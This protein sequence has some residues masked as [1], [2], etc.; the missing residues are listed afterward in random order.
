VDAEP[1]MP[2]LTDVAPTLHISTIKSWDNIAEWY[3]DIS[4][5]RIED[6][7]ELKEVYDSIFTNAKDLTPLKKAQKIYNYILGNIRYSHTSFRQGAYVPQKPSVTLNTRL[8]DC[9]DLS[10]LFVSLATM[11]GLKSHLVL[12]DTRDNGL[13]EM[14]LPSVEFNHCIVL[15]EAE[16][17]DYYLELT[18][19]E[20]PFG[21][22][23]YNL[24]GAMSL[25]I[26]TH[27]VEPMVGLLKP[28]TASHRSTDKVKRSG[29]IEFDGSDLKMKVD[30]V[31]TASLTSNLRDIYKN[32]SEEKKKEKLQEAIGGGFK[33]PVSI[34]TVNFKG[35]DALEDSVAYTYSFV[36]KNELI[37]VGDMNMVKVPFGDVVATMDNFSK[38]KREFP[39]EY[40]RYEDADNYE[41]VIT[42]NIPAG[43]KLIEVPKSESFQFGK[44][45]YSIEFLPVGDN[46]LQ[47][48]RKAKLERND[49]SPNEYGSFKEFLNKI[50]KVESKYIAFK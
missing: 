36:V 38:D 32:L 13:R 25:T 49:I 35:L 16:G 6:E 17:K 10:S 2:S 43:K 50:V 45:S 44:N 28:I 21:S 7:Y 9:K 31:R 3:S 1:F 48:T 30:I 24:P 42:V 29:S 46:K 20:L 33:N 19:N 37:E 27:T 15:L 26:P 23:P 11:A 14:T 22:L 40:W 4:H 8:G 18:D 39:V 5:L 47:I 41:T 34:S 12:V